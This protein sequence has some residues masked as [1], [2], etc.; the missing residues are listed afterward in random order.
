M[1]T[2]IEIAQAAQM[3]PITEIAAN[4]NIPDAAL[5]PYGRYKAKIDMRALGERPRRAKLILVTAINPTPAGAG[6]A[7]T[8]CWRCASR[9]WG[10]CSA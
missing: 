9:R 8:Q 1:P 2:D 3:L 5:I 6:W 10:R 4:L 7:Q